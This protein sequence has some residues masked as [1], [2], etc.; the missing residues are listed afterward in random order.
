MDTIINDRAR[1]LLKNA[2]PQ[3]GRMKRSAI[4]LSLELETRDEYLQWF[5]EKY[6]G[7]MSAKEIS[8]LILQTT[9]ISICARS[10]MR[11]VE[12]TVPL[13][14]VPEAFRNA[15]SRGRVRWQLVERSKKNKTQISPRIRMSIFERDGFK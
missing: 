12:E 13:R 3:N 15:I 10:V 11:T 9:G 6:A 5:G 7:G 14:K 4:A 1:E 8:D 2:K